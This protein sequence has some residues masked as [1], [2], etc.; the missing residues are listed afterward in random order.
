MQSTCQ[1]R[2]HAEVI[3]ICREILRGLQLRLSGVFES[4]FTMD[5]VCSGM[6]VTGDNS[7]SRDYQELGGG[8]VTGLKC[9]Q[10]ES[11][12]IL[13]GFVVQ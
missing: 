9:L 3:I 6:T 7:R 2:L 1:R 11:V 5:A 10:I 4:L 12:M 13:K 8:T